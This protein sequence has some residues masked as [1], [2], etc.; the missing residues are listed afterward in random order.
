[1]KNSRYMICMYVCTYI[2]TEV[3]V[4]MQN[5]T[6]QTTI[7]KGRQRLHVQA[8]VWTKLIIYNEIFRVYGTR[9]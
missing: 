2:C 4:C 7:G 5:N 6:A 9:N 8:R 3:C 1:M